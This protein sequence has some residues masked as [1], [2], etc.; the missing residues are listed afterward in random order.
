MPV[1]EAKDTGA[2]Y[3][4][5]VISS[6]PYMFETNELGKSFTLVRNPNWDPATDPNRKALPD[7]YEVTL[8]VNAD[9]IDNRLISGDLDVDIA[10]TGVQ[11]AVA[12]RG[13]QRPEPEGA[14][15]QPGRRA[16][17]VHRRSTRRSRR[18]TT[19]SA[20]RRS[21]TPPT[22]PATRPRTAARSPVATS[23]PR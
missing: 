8:N 10:G 4:E 17:L 20:A 11:P 21:C 7:R 12:G 6:G 19:S 2:K 3:K 22:A 1:P 5:H 18:S 14:G 15:R 23:R 13:P 9:D 16:A